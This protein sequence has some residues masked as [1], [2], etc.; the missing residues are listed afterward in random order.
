MGVLSA[1]LALSPSQVV[2][3]YFVFAPLALMAVCYEISSRVSGSGLLFPF[4]S[5]IRKSRFARFLI[6]VLFGAA[7][8]IGL[9]KSFSMP[10]VWMSAIVRVPVA[11]IAE[12]LLG[13]GAYLVLT[14][15]AVKPEERTAVE[16]VQWSEPV[17][18]AY[19][20]PESI[21]LYAKNPFRLLGADT[22]AQAADLYSRMMDGVNCLEVGLS[23]PYPVRELANAPEITK[24]M[25]QQAFEK[26]REALTRLDEECFWE[27]E[28]PDGTDAYAVHN[29]AVR[30]HAEVL[31]SEARPS[32]PKGTEASEQWRQRWRTALDMWGN[33]LEDG[34]F[35]SYLR[36]RATALG[37][38]GV[39]EDL[40][41]D[42]RER[43][44]RRILRVNTDLAYSALQAGLQA[45]AKS[46]LQ[47]VRETKL[48]GVDSVEVLRGF[49][50]S[51][52]ED[53]ERLLRLYPGDLSWEG[54]V[55]AVEKNAPAVA[56]L[57]QV[58]LPGE[59]DGLGVMRQLKTAMLAHLEDR[60]KDLRETVHSMRRPV[61]ESI[62]ALNRATEF[63]SKQGN[64]LL[65]LG[66]D[67]I[68]P[69]VNQHVDET[70]KAIRDALS[71]E[72]ELR[73]A[74]NQVNV[75]A[76]ELMALCAKAR[77]L[78]ASPDQDAAYN[79]MVAQIKAV[80]GAYDDLVPWLRNQLQTAKGLRI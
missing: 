41:P 16:A 45:R 12:L 71:R 47:L 61:N 20:L 11:W 29:S 48:Q 19:S 66:R 17:P 59:M 43:I 8:I 77:N 39:T 1:A 35:T 40:A 75:Q 5:F 24:S 78:C 10:V 3:L 26:T 74:Q 60:A 42:L 55:A 14:P 44:A 54:V 18:L 64:L 15:S 79:E 51:F 25:L 37:D 28:G 70:I 2:I 50:M 69:M 49:F 23:L 7:G 65:A 30:A 9:P 68:R 63:F 46:L 58:A 72:P 76:D 31:S 53:L 22:R 56:T 6:G 73:E 13:L 32:D 21:Y 27:W 34:E 67:T 36:E 33:A 57:W 62:E 38:P 80:K 52:M 4:F